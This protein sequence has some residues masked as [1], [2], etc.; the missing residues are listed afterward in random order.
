MLLVL[1]RAVLGRLA[2]AHV[3]VN[4]TGIGVSEAPH[5]H[6]GHSVLSPIIHKKREREKGEEREGRGKGREGEEGR[7]WDHEREG[8]AVPQSVARSHQLSKHHC[9]SYSLSKKNGIRKGKEVLTW[10]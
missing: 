8:D 10:V 4:G 7:S 9:Y 3:H 6:Q 1:V 5:G 2:L